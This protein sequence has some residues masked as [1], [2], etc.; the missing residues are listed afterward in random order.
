M[1]LQD[2]LAA[3]LKDKTTKFSKTNSKSLNRMKHNLKKN[4]HIISFADEV[5]KYR[6]NPVD[7][8]ESDEASDSDSDSSSDSDSDS[9]SESSKSDS[10]SDNVAW[11]Q[12]QR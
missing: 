10:D 11:R 1:N 6:A 3:A 5:E 4:E 2:D 7:D 9:D 12:R 8:E